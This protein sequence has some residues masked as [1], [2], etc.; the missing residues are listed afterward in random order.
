MAESVLPKLLPLGMALI[1]AGSVVLIVDRIIAYRLALV[2]LRMIV[3]V[4]QRVVLR[5]VEADRPPDSAVIRS[6]INESL[7]GFWGLWIPAGGGALGLPM[8]G[9]PLPR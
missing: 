4:T 2:K 3:D 6:L 9:P 5:A 1:G 8:R 7:A